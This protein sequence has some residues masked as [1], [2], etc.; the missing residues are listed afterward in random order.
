MPNANV[1]ER[2]VG[3]N[4]PAQGSLVIPAY[5]PTTTSAAVV[6]NQAGGAAVLTVGAAQMLSATS[7]TTLTGTTAV[8]F[9]G[10]PF[11]LR[12]VGKVTTGT[13]TNVTIAIQLGASTTVTTANNLV[14]TA[15]TAVNTAS[16]NFCVEV[17]ALWDSATA[18][19]AGMISPNCWIGTTNTPTS[20]VLSNSVA[21]T[22]Q[23]SLQ[24]VPVITAS[25][26]N[27]S[28]IVTITEFVAET[29]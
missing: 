3:S 26:T 11:R 25:A 15:A 9:D 8:N 14:I 19:V 10:F 6:L 20:A 5:S 4:S 13:S 22:A 16:V 21:A 23:T 28:T 17:T 27:A 24:F 29:V 18:K 12:L 2:L 7:P 1:I